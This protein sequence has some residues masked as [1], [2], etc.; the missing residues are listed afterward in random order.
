MSSLVVATCSGGLDY[1][2]R[3]GVVAED[4][5]QL[6]LLSSC[7]ARTGSV[8][9]GRELA[10]VFSVLSEEGREYF[11]VTLRNREGGFVSLILNP[12]PTPH[13]L[14]RP[15]FKIFLAKAT[16]SLLRLLPKSRDGSELVP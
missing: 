2:L 12:N 13:P 5:T 7:A 15:R 8:R 10:E 4:G 3:P 6:G 9:S 11:R 14:L 1:A 16:Y